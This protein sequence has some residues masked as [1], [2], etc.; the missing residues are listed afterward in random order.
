MIGRLARLASRDLPLPVDAAFRAAHDA[1]G[2]MP[3]W[4]V[5]EAAPGRGVIRATARTRLLG[6]TDDVTIRVEPSPRGGSRIQVRS[7]SRVGLYDFG[8][9]ARRIRRYL[10]ELAGDEP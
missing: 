1:A 5:V 8:T 2:R 6:F 10:A 3:R 7:A 4:T 9:N